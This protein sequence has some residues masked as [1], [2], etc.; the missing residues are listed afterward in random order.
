MGRRCSIPGLVLAIV[1]TFAVLPAAAA[2]VQLHW[3]LGSKEL[4]PGAPPLVF[5]SRGRIS[6]RVLTGAQAGMHVSCALTYKGEIWNPAPKGGGEARINTIAFST[7]KT[8]PTSCQIKKMSPIEA[9]GLPWQLKLFREGIDGQL[10]EG[11]IIERTQL[12]VRCGA[13]TASVF[14]GEARGPVSGHLL[15]PG[16]VLTQE[17]DGA[18]AEVGLN[19]KVMPPG[20]PLT[21]KV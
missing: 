7:C 12:E 5:H 15:S 21:I 13:G 11:I 10:A 14:E 9:L 6:V 4:K 17:S 3:F 2:P 20:P 19:I 8:T 16:G 1:L 18:Q